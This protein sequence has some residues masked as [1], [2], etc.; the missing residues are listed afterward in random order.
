MEERKVYLKYTGTGAAIWNVPARDLTKEEAETHGEERLLAS[1][2]YELA[3][4]SDQSAGGPLPEGTVYG[5]FKE[6]KEKFIPS[7]KGTI[8]KRGKKESDQ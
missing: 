6:V 7:T 2:I 5:D 8:R 1:G 4:K 3:E